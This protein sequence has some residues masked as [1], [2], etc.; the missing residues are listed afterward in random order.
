[1]KRPYEAWLQAWATWA[2]PLGCV[3]VLGLGLVVYQVGF[4]GRNL[5]LQS[6]LE[7]RQEDLAELR[8]VQEGVQGFL[9]RAA[10]VERGISVLYHDVFETEEE[11]FTDAV[12]EVKDLARRAGLAPLSFS[13]PEEVF[14]DHGL[15][16]RSFGF[17]VEGTYEQVRTLVNLLEL[18][19]HFLVLT[20]VGL[21]ESGG[22]SGP[23]SR[24]AIQLEISTIF[25][26]PHARVRKPE[27][28]E[29]EPSEGEPETLDGGPASD[30]AGGDPAGS[31][32]DE[33]PPDEGEDGNE[34]ANVNEGED[35]DVP[36]EDP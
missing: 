2:V 14:E 23:G 19:N 34:G 16:R 18:S 15:I 13:Y 26:D 1:M 22:G 33:A 20:S 10:S 31:S 30:E 9:E 12:R 4:S 36:E 28:L 24:L 6:N 17:N 11:R 8:R 3:L 21:T 7:S 29:D 32:A 35:E 27:A 5:V 25:A